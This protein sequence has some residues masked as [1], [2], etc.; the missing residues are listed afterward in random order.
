[1]IAIRIPQA[2]FILCACALTSQ[3]IAASIYKWKDINGKVHFGERPPA[4][5]Q[6]DK[7]KAP[8]SP[9]PSSVSPAKTGKPKI[10]IY[11]TAWCGYC[12]KAKAYFAANDMLYKEF[13]IEKDRFAKRDYDRIGGNGVPVILVGDQRM[14]GFSKKRFDRIYK[15]AK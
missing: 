10:V 1:M 7:L 12:K 15:L 3:A 6:V 8:P 13:D 4:N 5:Q 2:L 9:P 14:T 11:T